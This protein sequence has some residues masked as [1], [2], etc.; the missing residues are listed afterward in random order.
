MIRFHDNVRPLLTD[1]E[2]SPH[3]ENPNMGDVDAIMESV[4]VNGCYA[5]VFVSRSSDRIVKGHH[6]YQALRELG[7]TRW[8]IA[9][10]EGLDDED[11]IRILLADNKIATLARIDRRQEVDL[12]QVLQETEKKLQGTGFHEREMQEQLAKVA[13]EEESPLRFSGDHDTMPRDEACPCCGQ[14]TR[15]RRF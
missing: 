5:P 6:L 4:L 13:R 14:M 15:A 9:W 2:P 3:P 1:H 10:L 8:P 7:C 12:L 11:E